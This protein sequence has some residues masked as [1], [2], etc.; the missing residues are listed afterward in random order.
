MCASPRSTPARSAL[1]LLVGVTLMCTTFSTA[2]LAQSRDRKTTVTFS[3]PFELP[4]VGPQ[5][6]GPQVLPAGT[7]VFTL[8]DSLS[9]RHIVRVFSSD[10]SQVHAT[11]LAVPN[12]RLRATDK[13]VI[14]FAER[15]AGAP[16]AI[17]AWFYPGDT[18]GQEF[19]YPK[20]RAVELARITNQPVLYV[21]DEVAPLLV[22]PVKMASEPPVAALKVA[23]LGA[24]TPRG[25]DVS[26][27]E[28]VEAPPAQVARLPKTAG[29]L[30]LFGML[31]LLSVAAGLSLTRF[32]RC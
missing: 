22:A 28:V 30:P 31:G 3:Q 18:S 11:I 7:Y 13:T 15:A 17:R 14:T 16:P 23:P 25:E 5:G 20:R 26:I 21:P 4:G 29:N 9:D 1:V 27:A 32:R 12:Y 19:V 10:E 8:V 2:A 24:V 6:S